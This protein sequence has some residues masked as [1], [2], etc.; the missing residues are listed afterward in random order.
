MDKH[1][2]KKKRKRSHTEDS[3]SKKKPKKTHNKSNTT[4]GKDNLVTPQQEYAYSMPSVNHIGNKDVR[5][6]MRAKLH[7]ISRAEKKKRKEKRKKEREE[8]GD[9][10][11]PPQV[12][13]T[14]DNTREPD[15]TTVKQDDVEIKEDT[16][17]DEFA[18]YF[19]NKTTPKIMITTS[20]NLYNKG[21]VTLPFIKDLIAA[22]PNST[23]RKR[24]NFTLKQI[25]EY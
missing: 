14:L 5:A 24:R 25:I 19:D 7:A 13:R 21:R 23:Y 18:D 8:L 2:G 15:E 12:P 16:A 11:P 20:P 6:R 9:A 4:D 3:D 17:V 1:S 10:A 22:I